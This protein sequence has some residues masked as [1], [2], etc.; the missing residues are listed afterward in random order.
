MKFLLML[1]AESPLALCLI[2]SACH[3]AAGNG[4][5]DDVFVEIPK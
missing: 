4:V 5:Y 3:K 2:G 1:L